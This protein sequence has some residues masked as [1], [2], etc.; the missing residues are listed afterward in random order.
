ML[1]GRH[2]GLPVAI[3]RAVLLPD[4]FQKTDEDIADD[5]SQHSHTVR[6]EGT[7]AP[8]QSGHLYED[9]GLWQRVPRLNDE[10]DYAILPTARLAE[11]VVGQV[12]P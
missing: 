4:E 12:P 11:A 10:G 7:L 2:R 5:R 3:D 9:E 1:R 6:E 8:R